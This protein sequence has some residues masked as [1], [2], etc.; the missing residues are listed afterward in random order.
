ME[1]PFDFNNIFTDTNGFSEYL[2]LRQEQRAGEK[3]E[4]SREAEKEVPNNLRQRVT[5][6]C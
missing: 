5:R 2:F 3:K 6:D 1:R 4:A